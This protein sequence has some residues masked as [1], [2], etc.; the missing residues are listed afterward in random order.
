MK[1]IP[2]AIIM[3]VSIKEI[4]R[5]GEE[6]YFEVKFLENEKVH[7]VVNFIGDIQRIWDQVMDKVIL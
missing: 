1:K 4:P 6:S 7:S 5:G 3:V 2:R